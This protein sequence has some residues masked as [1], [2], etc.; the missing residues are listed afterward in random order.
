V[1]VHVHVHVHAFSSFTRNI[2]RPPQCFKVAGGVNELEARKEVV[3][4]SM[5]H[6][7]IADSQ[8]VLPAD[9]HLH[10]ASTMP[11]VCKAG[12]PAA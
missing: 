8:V 9:V 10:S 12:Y 6:L 7:D 4:D 2:S 1:H 3:L 5:A 11:C